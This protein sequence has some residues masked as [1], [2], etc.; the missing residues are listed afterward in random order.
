MLQVTGTA[1]NVKL[2]KQAG[3]E[4]QSHQTRGVHMN[5]P[6]DHT[7]MDKGVKMTVAVFCMMMKATNRVNQGKSADG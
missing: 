3:L 5:S 2:S 1:Q 7:V 6:Q 4:D